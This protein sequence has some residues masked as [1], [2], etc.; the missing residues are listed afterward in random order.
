MELLGGASSPASHVD[1]T[2][3]VPQANHRLGKVV[4]ETERTQA[5][6]AQQEESAGPRC[7]TEPARGKHPQKMPARKK[8]HVSVDG[9][10]TAHD[11]VGPGADFV[12]CLSSRAAVAE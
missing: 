4:L 5:R 3:V 12:R 10:D 8:Q 11:A 2:S 7:K 9:T 1:M 6:G